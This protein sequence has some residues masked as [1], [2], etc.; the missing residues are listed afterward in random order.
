MW[1]AIT[2]FA[3]LAVGF[4]PAPEVVGTWK[5]GP[6]RLEVTADGRF[7]WA[8]GARASDG[9]WSADATVLSLRTE[10]GEVTYAWRIE[11]DTLILA[12]PRGSEMVLRRA[13]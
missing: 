9:K 13:R 8:I 11:G 1:V 12:D 10:A 5:E 3:Q 7:D 4:G 2:M 6:V